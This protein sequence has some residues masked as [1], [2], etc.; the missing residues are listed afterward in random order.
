MHVDGDQ[1]ELV[2]DKFCKYWADRIAKLYR[3][4]FDGRLLK[5]VEDKPLQTYDG[6]G[7]EKFVSKLPFLTIIDS[8]NP[9]PKKSLSID[10][11]KHKELDLIRKKTITED[12]SNLKLEFV[13]D[14]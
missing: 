13:S 7:L 12:Q 8:I 10:F 9:P 3:K 14:K 4:Q 1:Q 11:E 6:E 2:R 5:L